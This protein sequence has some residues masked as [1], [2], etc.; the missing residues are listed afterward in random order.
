MR[1]RPLQAGDRAY[2]SR[3]S[4]NPISERHMPQASSELG[5]GLDLRFCM[6]YLHDAFVPVLAL[7]LPVSPLFV[8]VLVLL[9]A[10]VIILSHFLQGPHR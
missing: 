2:T 8:L 6:R 7:C 9:V 5:F 3:M 1:L 4:V 10:V